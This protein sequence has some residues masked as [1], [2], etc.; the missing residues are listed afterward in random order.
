MMAELHFH[1][2]RYGEAVAL[3]T[4]HHYSRRA[5]SNV[6][7]VGTFH[8]GGGLFGDYG[9]AVAACFFSLPPTRWSEEVWELS[10]LVR[11]TTARP[12]T[13]LIARTCDVARG[14]GADLLVSF[15]DSTQGHHGGVYQAASW[16]YGGKRDR[17]VDG[18]LIDGRFVP[19]RSC[20]STWG[21]RSPVKLS[22]ILGREVLPHYDEGK[23][24]YWRALTKEGRRRAARLGLQALPYPKPKNKEAAE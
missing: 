2:G 5:P 17:A 20:N 11:D 21:T 1:A 6:Q 19:G 12:L 15:A 13:S 10:R 4:R 23:H 7:C 9:A 16:S 24:L 22:T 8:E 18:V 3:V 14:K